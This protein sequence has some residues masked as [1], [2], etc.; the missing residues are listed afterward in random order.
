MGKLLFDTT[1]LS[2]AQ[3][4]D[5]EATCKALKENFRIEVPGYIDFKLEQFEA[6]NHH[7]KTTV[8]DAFAIKNICGDSYLLFVEIE[9]LAN[10]AKSKIKYQTE[11]Q[12]VGLVY[13]K[14]DF[15]RVFIRTETYID[16]MRELIFPIE[17][18]FSEDRPFSKRFYVLTDD[19]YKTALAMQQDFRDAMM[20]IKE[21]DFVVEI[22]EHTLI[23]SNPKPLT[24]EHTLY[25]ADFVARLAALKC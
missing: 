2:A 23:I 18:D 7:H 15:G 22:F 11:Q 20:A 9:A 5:F 13:L 1:G 21:T 14:R 25:L 17:L 16:K 19:K 12:P 8:R 10:P 24:P 4:N 6:L 3:I